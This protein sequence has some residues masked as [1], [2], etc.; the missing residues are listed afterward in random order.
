[1]SN[2]DSFWA[3]FCTSWKV[4]AIVCGEKYHHC[5]TWNGN[6]SRLIT[7]WNDK[8]VISKHSHS[9]F[10]LQG[11]TNCIFRG[12][13]NT[14]SAGDG[15][16]FRTSFILP[17]GTHHSTTSIMSRCEYRNTLTKP[18]VGVLI[19][20]KVLDERSSM[21][22]CG[23]HIQNVKLTFGESP[24]ICLGTFFLVTILSTVFAVPLI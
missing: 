4:I 13:G 12:G 19:G 17:V 18:T 9:G 10:T 22:T 16:L 3:M 20:E 6:K 8:Q 14:P 24:K 1:M 23:W 7:G 5:L 11:N 15:K 2:L 21:L